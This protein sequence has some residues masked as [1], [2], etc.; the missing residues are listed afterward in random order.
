MVHRIIIT[1]LVNLVMLVACAVAA[2]AVVLAV[3]WV[4][5]HACSDPDPHR[6]L[7][8]A[9]IAPFGVVL[10]GF[11]VEQADGLIGTVRPT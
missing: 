11:L 6:R 10:F 1:G 8:F 2:I 9:L 3:N 4:Q 7:L 5:R